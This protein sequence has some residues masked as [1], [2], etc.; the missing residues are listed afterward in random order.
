MEP[1]AAAN[2]AEDHSK[3]VNALIAGFL[4]WAIDAF[5]FFV[6]VF[7]LS[8]VAKDF[9][10][11][12][13]EIALTIT[14]SLAMR[15]VGAFIFGLLADR[16]G[17]RR[18]LMAVVIFYSLMEVLSG[19]APTYTAFL[20]LRLLYGIGMGGE[21]GVGASLTMESV[22]QRWRGMASGLLQEGYTFGYILAAICYFFVYPHWGWR[23]M[24]FIGAAP[25]VITLY[26]CARVEEP[27]AWHESRTDAAT[28]R[29]LIFKNWKLF[30]YLVILMA[31]MSFISHGTQDLYPTFLQRQRNYS[32]QATAIITIIS[33]VGAMLGGFIFG[34]FS[35]RIGRRRAM[36]TALL[37]AAASIPLWVM[38]PN[39]PLI[40]LGAFIMQFM[41]QG[42]WGVIPAHLSEL[43]PGELRG[44]FP[45]FAYQVGILIASSISYVEAL[46]GEHFSY[47]AALAV[48]AAIVLIVGA[49]VIRVGPEAKGI[50]FVR[51]ESSPAQL[52]GAAQE[53][54]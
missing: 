32:V 39:R 30:G 8:A 5:D 15:P 48:L 23:P 42:A 38:A 28:Y 10:R 29:R 19:L 51:P 52:A 49:V 47:S 37:L 41:V 13:P 6:L 24:F 50:S 18:L 4:G 54:T 14:G 7:I 45:G 31:M 1:V 12:I 20:V 16:Y 26:F 17:R 25:A 3:A 21:W 43:S 34:H 9:G 2:P 40:I 33:M 36:I 53:K 46:L 11:S 44:F 22:P 27:R 35:D